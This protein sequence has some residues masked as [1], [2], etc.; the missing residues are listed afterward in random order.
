MVFAWYQSEQIIHNYTEFQVSVIIFMNLEEKK[1]LV[2]QLHQEGKNQRD[3]SSSSY[4]C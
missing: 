4:V 3:C 2:K 1:N